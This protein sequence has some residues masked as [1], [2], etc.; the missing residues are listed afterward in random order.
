MIP[1]RTPR[2]NVGFEMLM[3]QPANNLNSF[4]AWLN[5]CIALNPVRVWRKERTAQQTWFEIHRAG[6][7]IDLATHLGFEEAK[8]IA[9]LAADRAV[10]V[11]ARDALDLVCLHAEAERLRD[12]A[13]IV[14]S[15]T[16]M[17]A[18]RVVR[19]EAVMTR[20]QAQFAKERAELSMA[21]G[22]DPTTTTRVA[23]QM[24]SAAA[25]ANAAKRGAWGL[26]PETRAAPSLDEEDMFLCSALRDVVPWARVRKALL[27]RGIEA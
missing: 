16:A 22:H 13:P 24:M 12:I 4:D 8:T 14:D 15:N 26:V 7:L 11:H 3:Q 9:Y 2:S 5:T 10:R 25:A 17:H 21:T 6:W 23:D 18:E 27:M 1:V 20:L 19:S